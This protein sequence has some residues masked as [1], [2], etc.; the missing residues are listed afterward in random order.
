V[1][2]TWSQWPW[3]ENGR[4]QDGAAA[5]IDGPQPADALPRLQADA[6]GSVHLP[7]VVGLGGAGD[8]AGGSAADGGRSQVGAIEPAAHG[9]LAGDGSA[10]MFAAQHEA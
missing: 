2:G 8:A 10:G 3:G 6:L 7:D 1:T 9:A 4:P 5:L